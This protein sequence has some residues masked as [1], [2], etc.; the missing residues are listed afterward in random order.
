MIKVCFQTIL[1]F[2]LTS[3]ENLKASLKLIFENIDWKLNIKWDLKIYV[4]LFFLSKL[5]IIIN[6][7]GWNLVSFGF[8]GDMLFSTLYKPSQGGTIQNQY[9]TGLTT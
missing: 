5:K 4:A 1:W 2:V 6:L 9:A 3:I 8:W 7:D